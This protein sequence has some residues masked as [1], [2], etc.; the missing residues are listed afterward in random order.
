MTELIL[1]EKPCTR[2]GEVKPATAFCKDKSKRGGFKSQCKKCYLARC[3]PSHIV[4]AAS[5]AWKKAN[6]ERYK[7]STLAWR[8]AN[9]ER[10][11][12]TKAAY[13]KAWSKANPEKVKAAIAAWRKAN[14]E[15]RSIYRQTRRAKL[16]GNGGKL[17]KGLAGKL[18]K[19]QKG[20]CPCCKQPL[21][22]DYH[23]D[24]IVPIALGGPNIDSNIQLL[25]QRCNNQ[26]SKKHPV[27]FMQSRGFLI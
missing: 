16:Y 21:G 15:T 6:P 2:C 10:V 20:K 1:T 27:D 8:K 3:R 18:F 17:S 23:L 22:T 25:R 7:A 14:P 5:K 13:S 11:K 19:L 26:K 9:P 4:N 12:Y 24:H